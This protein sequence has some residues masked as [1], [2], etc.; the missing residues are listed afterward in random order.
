MHGAPGRAP[1]RQGAFSGLSRR[2][3]SGGNRDAPR[4]C[5]AAAGRAKPRGSSA[6][7]GA[8]ELGATLL[9]PV[10]RKA[11][12]RHFKWRT[13]AVRRNLIRCAPGRVN[14]PAGRAKRDVFEAGTAATSPHNC[15]SDRRTTA[16]R[17][18][19]ASSDRSGEAYR[20]RGRRPSGVDTGEPASPS[21]RRDRDAH[22]STPDMSHVA[23]THALRVEAELERLEA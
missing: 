13:D 11:L 20:A 19:R 1:Q 5:T 9:P 22:L 7:H 2:R 14:P 15:S 3:V 8:R 16:S 21:R 23:E 10:T 18:R 6:N 17:S 4:L 12:P